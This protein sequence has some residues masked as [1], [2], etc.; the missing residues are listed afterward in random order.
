M[1]DPTPVPFRLPANA[2]RS[3][4]AHSFGIVRIDF[5]V[6]H[7]DSSDMLAV[8]MTAS[9]PGGPERHFHHAQEEWFYVLAGEFLFEING[10]RTTHAVGDTLYVPRRTPHAWAATSPAGGK[11]L[12]VFTPA[13]PM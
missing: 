4:A 11:L 8:E 5:K 6:M 3:G 1:P 12:I 13:G 7:T 2:D 9:R 10:E